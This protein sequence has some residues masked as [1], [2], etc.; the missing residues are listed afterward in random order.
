MSVFLF[1]AAITATANASEFTQNDIKTRVGET[2]YSHIGKENNKTR[3]QE[4]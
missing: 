3:R 2:F 1:H 4:V